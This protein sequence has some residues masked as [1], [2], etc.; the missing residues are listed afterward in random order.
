MNIRSLFQLCLPSPI[1]FINYI[2]NKLTEFNI[3]RLFSLVNPENRMI[4]FAFDLMLP[5]RCTMAKLLGTV[6]GSFKG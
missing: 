6:D 4:D 1:K 2:L 3:T 5:C